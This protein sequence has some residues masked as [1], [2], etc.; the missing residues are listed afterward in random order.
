MK[1]HF[2]STTDDYHK[3]MLDSLCWEVTLSI[4]LENP[5]SPCRDV[6]LKDGSFGNLLYDFL[7]TVIPM[8]KVRRI[9]EIG[10][11]YGYLMRD[12]LRRNGMLQ[13][14]MIDLSP[15]L[16]S[17]Q[18]QTLAG[19]AVKFLQADFLKLNMKDCILSLIDLAILN[20]VI[21]DFPT[22]CD[23]S[24]DAF[25]EGSLLSDPILGEIMRLY[26]SYRISPPS[27]DLFAVNLGA[28]QA[29]EKLCCARVPYIYV[30]E[31]SCEAT[32]PEGW[33]GLMQIA[34]TGNPERIRLHGHDEYSI[35]FSD[36]EKVASA[37]GYTVKRGRYL[38]FIEPVIHGEVSF[39]LH[40]GSSR[41]ARYEI[42][43]QFIEDLVKYE[44]LVLSLP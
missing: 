4:M 5:K 35:R 42:I 44:Y 30:S 27:S 18:R 1:G 12:F 31:H 3:R 29:I 41:I 10:G 7:D 11:G 37:L 20:E 21:G 33:Q 14:A 24:R 25:Q 38:D 39:V 15:F 19:Y 26:G 36:L 22:A 28:I 32:V 13:A 40:L 43:G 6:L 23:I 2:L 8:H 17:W 16:L 9:A 34:A